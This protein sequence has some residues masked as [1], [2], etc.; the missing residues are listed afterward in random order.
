MSERAEAPVVV[1]LTGQLGNQLFQ[2]AAGRTLADR[3]GAPLRFEPARRSAPLRRCV[4]D[5]CQLATAAELRR[6]GVYSMRYTALPALAGRRLR[7]R[8]RA[9]RGAAP[10]FFE[11]PALGPYDPAFERLVAPSYLEGYFQLPQYFEA[12]LDPVRARVIDHLHIGPRWAATGSGD[13]PVVGVHFR[14]G[15]FVGLGWALGLDYY[16]HAL[17]VVRERSPEAHIRVFS[18]DRVFAA[19]VEEHLVGRGFTMAPPA[20][21]LAAA[22]PGHDDPTI[23][24]LVA[25]ARCDHLI[26]ANSTFSWWAGAIG[27]HLDGSIDRLVICPSAWHPDRGR[28]ELPRSEWLVIDNHDF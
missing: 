20:P 2:L 26:M 22:V 24:T 4:G 3:L 9:L 12:G 28:D 19:L 10:R 11:P 25:M 16:D 17:A 18:D 23:A 14:R 7:A 13:A 6:C 15:D 1:R 5:A 21:E 8:S 27:D